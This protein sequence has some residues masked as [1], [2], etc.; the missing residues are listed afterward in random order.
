M[1]PEDR[2]LVGVINRK[3]DL[4]HALDSRWYRIPQKQAPHGVHAEYVGF[5]LSGK[6]FKEQSGAIHY[7]APIIGLELLYR[8]DLMPEEADHPRAD[9]A[10]YRLALGEVQHKDPPI[11]NPSRRVISFIYT[12][13]DRFIHASQ[14]SDLYSQSDY[15]VDRIYHALREKG[16]RARRGWDAQESALT[17]APGMRVLC[18]NGSIDVSPKRKTGAYFL[19][20]N[21]PQ[22]KILAEIL[23]EIDRRGGPATINIPMEGY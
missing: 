20:E 21:Q 14:I 12:T 13:W 17:Y 3:R 7:Y 5:F 6:V 9:D 10:Y 2:V 15:F 19:D 23:A 8:R 1:N 16:I 18:E 4:N 11:L 22:D